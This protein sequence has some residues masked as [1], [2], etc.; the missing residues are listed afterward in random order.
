MQLLSKPQSQKSA[1][2]ERVLWIFTWMFSSYS[3]SLILQYALSVNNK[4]K[5]KQKPNEQNPRY[6]LLQLSAIENSGSCSEVLELAYPGSQEPLLLMFSPPCVQWNHFG[7]LGVSM[8]GRFTPQKSANSTNLV[9]VAPGESVVKHLPG[10]PW[11]VFQ[12]WLTKDTQSNRWHMVS[13]CKQHA[14]HGTKT[15]NES[16]SNNTCHFKQHPYSWGEHRLRVK[17]KRNI[18]IFLMKQ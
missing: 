17:I 11:Q 1:S 4:K 6:R 3:L 8:V 9:F 14:S 12:R 18:P 2:R 16:C 15:P 10:H 7:S 5:Q 13:E